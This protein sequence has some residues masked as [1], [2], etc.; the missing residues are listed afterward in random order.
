MSDLDPS[1]S[2]MELS[3][4]VQQAAEISRQHRLRTGPC[5][6]DLL[7]ADHLVGD[8]GVLDAEGA[9][10]AAADLGSGEFRQAQPADRLEQPTRLVPDAELA[11]PR[12]PVVIGD[13]AFPACRNPLHPTDVD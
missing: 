8:V 10:E 11:Q 12:A 5:D 9:P 2:A 1:T 6:V 7:V 13:P 3:C 4:D